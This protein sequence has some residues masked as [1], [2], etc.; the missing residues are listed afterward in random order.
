MKEIQT[1]AR[2]YA[3]AL[4]ELA[5]Q[6]ESINNW[7]AVLSLL[8]TAIEDSQ[9]LKLLGHPDLSA[10]MLVETLFEV[11]KKEKHIK[12]EELNMV[13]HAL[14]VMA[15]HQRL[16]VIPEVS[17]QFEELRAEQAKMCSG[18]VY[19]SVQLDAKQLQKLEAGLKKKLNKTVHL[20][21]VVQ[22]TL[23]GGARVQI[24][25]MVID[26][27]LRGRLERLSQAL[28]V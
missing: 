24:G 26:G 2:P 7:S 5:L 20:T 25:D 11:V 8:S 17:R 23:L 12:K 19:T 14:V 22:P 13:E 9:M 6:H 1:I 21:Q 15:N 3:K 27:T 28:V 10:Q 4:F 16:A 18:T